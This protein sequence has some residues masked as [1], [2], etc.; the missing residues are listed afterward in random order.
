MNWE[1][2]ASIFQ[3]KNITAV[4]FFYCFQKKIHFFPKNYR[5][6]LDWKQRAFKIKSENLYS[7]DRL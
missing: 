3:L 6:I 7:L 2:L 4:C 1:I 5:N